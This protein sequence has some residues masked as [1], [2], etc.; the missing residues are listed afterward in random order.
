[1]KKNLT[2][3][4]FI[5]DA[6]GSMYPLTED[7]IGGFNSVLEEQKKVG[8]EAL[9]T[10]VLFNTKSTM[11]HD[12]IPISEVPPLTEDDYRACGCT[13]L[14]DAIGCTIKHI[15]DIHRYIREEDVPENTL[16]VITTDGAEN[17]SHLYTGNELKHMIRHRREEYGWEFMFLAENIDA[18]ETA[19]FLGIDRGSAANCAGSSEGTRQKFSAVNRACTSLR[20][21]GEKGEEWKNELKCDKII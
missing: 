16:F 17:S 2:E 12:R 9:V 7:T 14:V 20:R 1:M 13:A 18:V 11:I 21:N 6:S 8:G 4:V 19:A 5:I 10:T 15:A 3:L